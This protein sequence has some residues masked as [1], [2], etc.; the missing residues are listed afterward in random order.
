MARA[1]S[2]PPHDAP[3]AAQ[4]FARSL[5]RGKGSARFFARSIRGGAVATVVMGA[6]LSCGSG[7]SGPSSDPTAYTESA[8]QDGTTDVTHLFAVGVVQVT[9]ELAFCS[10]VLLA[11]NLVATARHCVAQTP[12]QQIDCS[13]TVFGPVYPVADLLVTTASMLSPQADFA[14]VVQVVVPSGADQTHVCGND[15]ALM[16]LDRNIELPQYVEPTISPP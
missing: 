8:I 12:Q 10:G 6:A 13:T 3:P 7:G 9:Q 15:I 14:H 1:P 5:H 2:K 11:P 16:I 4:R